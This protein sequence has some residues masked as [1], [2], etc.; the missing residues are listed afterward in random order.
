M[1]HLVHYSNRP[2]L[3]QRLRDVLKRI[4]ENDQTDYGGIKP[5]A[6]RQEP[7]QTQ[8]LSQGQAE[9]IFAC[10]RDGTGPRELSKRFGITERAI[11]YL[12]KKYGVQ[13]RRGEAVEGGA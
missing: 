9:T 10:Y 5:A 4:A 13:R 6:P 3:L 8:Q 11:K 2:E 1:E 12:L 7:C